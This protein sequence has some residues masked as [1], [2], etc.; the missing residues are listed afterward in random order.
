MGRKYTI[1]SRLTYLCFSP[2]GELLYRRTGNTMAER[3]Y[4][5]AL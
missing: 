2:D 3:R 1:L 4:L 5:Q